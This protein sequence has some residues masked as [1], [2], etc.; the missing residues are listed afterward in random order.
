MDANIFRVNTS[1]SWIRWS[2]YRSSAGS[3]SICFPRRRYVQITKSKGRFS[4]ADVRGPGAYS[5]I[6][7]SYAPASGGADGSLLLSSNEIQRIENVPLQAYHDWLSGFY[8]NYSNQTSAAD[9]IQFAASHAIVTCPGGPQVKTVSINRRSRSALLTTSWLSAEQ[10][11]RPQAQKTSYQCHSDQDPITIP[12]SSYLKTKGS[13]P[14]ILPLWWERTVHR[15]PLTRPRTGSLQAGPKILLPV[16]GTTIT[17]PK[18][19]IHLRESTALSL[20]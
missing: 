6:L 11:Q 12:S 18:R 9:L 7:P 5:S 14:L 3:N 2:M 8:D 19:T 20:I 16:N 4:F 1:V 17:T 13:A 15:K 10:T